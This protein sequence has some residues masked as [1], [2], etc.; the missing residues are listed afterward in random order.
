MAKTSGG[1]R[2]F[3]FFF[4]LSLVRFCYYVLEVSESFSEHISSFS[5]L[6]GS[7]SQP[8]PL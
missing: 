6:G 2:R 4:F 5:R 7:L 8:L 1:E 3:C